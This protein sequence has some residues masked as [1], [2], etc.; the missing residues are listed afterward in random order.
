MAIYMKTDL[1]ACHT[2]RAGCDHERE[3]LIPL[4]LVEKPKKGLSVLAR[5]SNKNSAFLKHQIYLLT[6]VLG[7][8]ESS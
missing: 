8:R 3:V 1:F 4:K 6:Q 7:R 2:P 5:A